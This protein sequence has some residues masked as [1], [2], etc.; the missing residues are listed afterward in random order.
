MA[1]GIEFTCYF[2]ARFGPLQFGVVLVFF[3]IQSHHPMLVNLNAYKEMT[4]PFP[5]QFFCSSVPLDW[6]P[7]IVIWRKK[8][9]CGIYFYSL[10]YSIFYNA[11]EN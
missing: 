2:C 9:I 6:V 7:I 4:Y 11:R 3:Q 10:N 8:I 5:C 1:L